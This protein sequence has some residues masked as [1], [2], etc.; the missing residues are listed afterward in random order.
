MSDPAQRE[1]AVFIAAL[2]LTE[3][4][5]AAYLQEVC[6]GDAQLRTRVEGLL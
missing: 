3:G 6:G 5:R 1:E 2:K 4:Q